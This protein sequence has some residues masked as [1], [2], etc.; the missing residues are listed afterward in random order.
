MWQKVFLLGMRRGEHPSN[1]GVLQNEDVLNLPPHPGCQWQIQVLVGIPE[2][3]GTVTFL[4]GG[5]DAKKL[6]AGLGCDATF[7]CNASAWECYECCQ[8]H[9]PCVRCHATTCG[10]GAL[11]GS[12]RGDV[13]FSTSAVAAAC[14]TTTV[15]TTPRLGRG[16]SSTEVPMWQGRVIDRIDR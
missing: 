3:V 1:V 2:L 15:S 12:C 7:G 8:C 5:V 13:D 10:T 11:G 9:R 16:G 6:L 4:S 14:A